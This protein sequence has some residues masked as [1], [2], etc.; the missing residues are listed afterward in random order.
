MLT[1][2]Y[3]GQTLRLTVPVESLD[4]GSIGNTIRVRNMQSRRIVVAQVVDAETVRVP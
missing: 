1:L 4:D 3:A 2:V